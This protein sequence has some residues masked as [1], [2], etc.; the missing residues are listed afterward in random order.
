MITFKSRFA[1]VTIFCLASFASCNSNKN[2]ESK[3][4]A[5][6][7]S[8]SLSSKNFALAYQ[9][10]EKIVATS[11]D[12]MKQ[13]SFGGAMDPA[14]SPDGNKL[15]YTVNDTIGNRTIWVADLENK[16]QSQLQVNSNNYYQAMWSPNGN[17][18][19]F[20][21][22]NGKNLWKVGVIRAD[23]TGYVMLDSA[24]AINVYS[25]T[26]KNEKELV[27]HDLKNLYTFNTAGKLIDTKLIADLIGKEFTL[28][29][30]NR[31][32]YTKDGTKLIFNA[33][34]ADILDG[35]MGPSEAAYI[36]DIASKKI[37]RLSPK[38]VNVPYIFVTADDR[39]FYSGSEK[40]YTQ[41]KIYVSD[42]KGNIK[43]IVDKGSNPTGALK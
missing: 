3:S 2:E 9:D 37:E 5:M 42:L 27:A 12:T 4:T 23:N 31:F 21:I 20:N 35:L 8:I 24:S 32:F 43:T 25:P 1:A 22:F 38:G 41:S 29:S 30:S 40:P 28:A 15:A 10:G 17:A 6:L 19:A 39:I 36:L 34:N 11:I 16:S 13:I 33:G 18:I 14:I 26:W 7:D